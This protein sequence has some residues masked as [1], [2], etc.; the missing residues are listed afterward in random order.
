[1]LNQDIKRQPKSKSALTLPKDES[2]SDQVILTNQS[3]SES[4]QVL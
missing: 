3:H 4:I 2:Y 1:M